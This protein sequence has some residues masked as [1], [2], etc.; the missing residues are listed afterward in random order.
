MPFGRRRLRLDRL[1]T[2]IYLYTERNTFIQILNPEMSSAIGN[3]PEPVRRVFQE[4]AILRFP[5][6]SLPTLFTTKTLHALHYDRFAASAERQGQ[7]S[8]A[9]SRFPNLQPDQPQGISGGF[10]F[11]PGNTGVPARSDIDAAPG[12]VGATRLLFGAPQW[13]IEHHNIV[14]DDD[15]FWVRRFALG[16]RRRFRLGRNKQ[17]QQEQGGQ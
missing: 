16:F 5:G 7:L 10:P 11:L 4:I 2:R 3:N 1:G 15:F 13:G 9:D 14:G 8:D 12:R 6:I 17:G